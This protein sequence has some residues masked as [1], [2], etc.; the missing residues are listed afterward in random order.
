MVRR[1]ANSRNVAKT[2]GSLSI[3]G[4]SNAGNNA[5]LSF[6]APESQ[7]LRA[8]FAGF[9]DL[10]CETIPELRRAQHLKNELRGLLIQLGVVPELFFSDDLGPV[11]LVCSQLLSNL[12]RTVLTRTEPVDGRDAPFLGR[13]HEIFNQSRFRTEFEEMEVIGK[14]GFGQVYRVRS[15]LDK[16]EYA[17]KKIVAR[18]DAEQ[19]SQRILHEVQILASLQHANVVRYHCGWIEMESAPSASSSSSFTPGRPLPRVRKDSPRINIQE[20]FDSDDDAS[21]PVEPSLNGGDSS[22]ASLSSVHNVVGKASPVGGRFWNAESSTDSVDEVSTE[23]ELSPVLATAIPL[24]KM[25]GEKGEEKWKSGEMEVEETKEVALMQLKVRMVIYIQ[26]ELCTSTLERYLF[27]RNEQ[28]IRQS[29]SSVDGVESLS[30]F[31]QLVSAMEYIHEKGLIHRDIKPGNLFLKAD[32]RSS[33]KLLLGDFGLSCIDG[34]E[35]EDMEA[36]GDHSVLASRTHSIGVG[37]VTYA[38]PEQMR[39]NRYGREVDIFSSGIVLLELFS[40]VGT[41]SERL[42]VIEKL[43]EERKLPSTVEEKWPSVCSMVLRLTSLDA[44]ERPTAT[45]LLNELSEEGSEVRSLREMVCNQ[46]SE[47]ETMRKEIKRLKMALSKKK[48]R[49]RTG[50]SHSSL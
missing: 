36:R 32:R 41:G 33:L 15:R 3:P 9:I 7:G 12:V 2:D 45:A 18:D 31:R 30:L 6:N 16:H 21:V 47:M 10:Y 34:D 5:M 39:T 48:N 29:V 14:G 19:L 8:L 37:T 1:L 13:A 4:P 38:A 44:G 40:I 11:R 42:N 26:M 28:L 46:K 22:M 17:L 49:V 20:I 35:E 24:A 25:S 27:K 43:R 50:D 23:V